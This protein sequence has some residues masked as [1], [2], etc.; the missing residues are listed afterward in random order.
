MTL[1]KTIVS[2]LKVNMILYGSIV[3]YDYRMGTDGKY[4]IPSIGIELSL[5]NVQTGRVLFA[6]SFAQSG[7]QGE[8]LEDTAQSL[9]S[10]IFGEM[11]R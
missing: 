3:E 4:D 9:A 11:D 10:A 8:S 2:K 5:L 7:K 1:A 6:G